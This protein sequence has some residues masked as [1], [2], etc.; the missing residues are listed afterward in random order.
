M[1]ARP[2]FLADIVQPSA[3]PNISRAISRGVDRP[4]PSSRCL[5]NQAF[6]AKRHAS[7][8][9]GLRY[10]SHSARTARRFASETGCPPPELLVT[11]TITSGTRS[12][13]RSSRRS[14][15]ADV[16]VSLERVD[17]CGLPRFRDDQVARVGLFH[18]DVRARGVEVVVV[19]D[20]V[21]GRE[22]RV[23]QN[24]LRRAALVCRNDV[25]EAGEIADDALEPVEG[26]AA[27]V[28]LV[29]LHQ[30]APL[31]GRHR[32]GAGVGEQI[33]EHVFAAQAEDVVPRGRQR[34]DPFVA[35]REL[36]AST[37]L[38][39]NGSMIVWK[40]I[41]PRLVR[42]VLSPRRTPRTQ[43]NDTSLT[44]VFRVSLW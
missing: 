36:T 44:F 21:P 39:R 28:R 41:S 35:G 5:M 25:G 24:P 11:V 26:A 31:R 10:R 33:D 23:E 18:L 29:A 2:S 20:D 3:R 15:R 27:G 38:I 14:Q 19:R 17:Q 40:F 4:Y 13:S 43:R 1:F 42:D 9:N 22:N 30:R 32:A 6:S 12:P 37:D 8:K 7:R 16:D 34:R